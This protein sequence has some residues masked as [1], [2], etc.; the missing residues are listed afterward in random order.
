MSGRVRR[1]ACVLGAVVVLAC[2]RRIDIGSEGPI[3]WPDDVLAC[4]SHSDCII[5]SLG[6]CSETVV[7]RK[8]VD[9]AREALARSGRPYC[10][11]KAA[12]GPST[13]GSWD[14]ERGHCVNGKC[15][16]PP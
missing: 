13:R 9:V 4:A 10:A 11:V 1:A 2:S 14:G 5:I 15:A 6:C 7:N 12:C 8:R 16:W 3:V